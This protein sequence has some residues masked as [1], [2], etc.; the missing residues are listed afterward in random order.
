M[1]ISIVWVVVIAAIAVGAGYIFRMLDSR[2]TTALKE[3]LEKAPAPEEAR[4]DFRP[5]EPSVLRVTLDQTLRWHLELDGAQIEPDGLTPE[6]RA[7]LVNVIVQIR[8][9]ID[10]K[11]AV[12][13]GLVAA[14]VPALPVASPRPSYAEL[15]PTPQPPPAAALRIDIGRGFRTM[16]ENDLKKPEVVKPTS[17]VSMI[18]DVLQ[19]ILAVSPLAARKI[20]LEEGPGGE[21]VVFVDKES[22]N[23]VDSV[24]YDDV[25]AII[26]QAI[27]E[28]DRKN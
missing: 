15:V 3:S 2:V 23:G 22:Y 25:R 12:S 18:D 27:T 13:P 16:L 26:R 4:P 14:P 8:P 28:W 9:W 11:T 20:R 1:E 21:V 6:Q 5:A 7:R 17:I 10:G 24:P 19:K